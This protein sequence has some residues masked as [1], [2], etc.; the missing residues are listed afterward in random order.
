MT[1]VKEKV[2]RGQ[3]DVLFGCRYTVVINVEDGII[4][5]INVA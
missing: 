3:V 1:A 2:D 5:L 4:I